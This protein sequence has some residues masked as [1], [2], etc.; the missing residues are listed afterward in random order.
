MLAA[1]AHKSNQVPPEVEDHTDDLDQSQSTSASL[2]QSL[3]MPRVHSSSEE[4]DTD[5]ET[6]F[7]SDA[8][9]EIYKDWISCQKK[10]DQKLMALILMD[11]F[12]E[13]FGMTDVGAA[14]EAGLVTGFNEKSV[15]TSRNDFY[16]NGGEFSES[17]K[18]E[19]IRP[20]VLHDEE[21]KGKALS[22][23]HDHTYAKGEPALTAA[24]FA[25]WVNSELLPISNQTF[26]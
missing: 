23:L 14:S 1:K 13:R 16:K 2:N 10:D 5:T 20:Y 21:C 8:A 26:Q 3:I 11:T 22:W 17:H 4:S 25:Q 7:N 19:H 12:I 15:R 18:G 9:K 6:S 24:R